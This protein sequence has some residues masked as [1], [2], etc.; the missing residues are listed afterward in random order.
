MRLKAAIHFIRYTQLLLVFGLI[1]IIFAVLNRS[2]AMPFMRIEMCLGGAAILLF[3]CRRQAVAYVIR[4]N[5]YP[6]VL[7]AVLKKLGVTLQRDAP[8]YDQLLD[9]VYN[10]HYSTEQF[11]VDNKLATSFELNQKTRHYNIKYNEQGL[12]LYDRTLAWKDIF[13]WRYVGAYRSQPA[14]IIISFYNELGDASE[15]AMEVNMFF[16]HHIDQ[17]ILLTH[18]QGKYGERSGV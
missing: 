17:M 4:T 2:E 7:Y 12:W 8:S 11:V 1:S 10:P 9:E 14:Q 18:F 3:I 5:K 15:A 6:G 13:D 16:T